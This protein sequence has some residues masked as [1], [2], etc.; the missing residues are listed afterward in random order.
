ML[1]I[2]DVHKRSM[3]I[4][5]EDFW[6]FSVDVWL[7]KIFYSVLENQGISLEEFY[8]KNI[9]WITPNWKDIFIFCFSDYKNTNK[10]IDDLESE[11][12]SDIKSSDIYLYINNKIEKYG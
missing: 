8:D 2:I 3:K 4:L 7:T 5:R 12:H 1:E 9:R 11:W 6:D 10:F